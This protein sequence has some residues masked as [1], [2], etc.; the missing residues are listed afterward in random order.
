[1][2]G[3][4]GFWLNLDRCGERAFWMRNRLSELGLSVHYRRVA[5]VEGD[6]NEASCRGLKPGEW[7][8]WQGWIRMLDRASQSSASI[9]HLMEDDI[10]ISDSFLRL[11]EDDLLSGLI[12]RRHVFCTDA[13]VSPRQCLGLLHAVAEARRDGR[14]WLEVTDGFK[15]PCL[16]SLL[17]APDVAGHLCAQLQEILNTADSL[18]AVDIAMAEV[19]NSWSTIVPFV[20]SPKL[21]LASV[22]ETRTDNEVDS[23]LSR[24]ALTLLRRSLFCSDDDLDFKIGLADLMVQLARV[25]VLRPY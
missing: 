21:H 22:G 1:M 6:V 16:N 5:G 24:D 7:G 20:T 13:Y 12:V 25:G 2:V 17:M 10:D 3:L 14:Q 11:V 15:I 8:A 4:Q 23:L 18:C 19:S 9:V